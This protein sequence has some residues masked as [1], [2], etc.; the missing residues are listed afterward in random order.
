MSVVE[1]FSADELDWIGCAHRHDEV[2]FRT[3]TGPGR[4]DLE[5]LEQLFFVLSPFPHDTVQ[6]VRT[7]DLPTDM[8]GA[9]AEDAY[10]ALSGGSTL[11]IREAHLRLPQIAVLASE[12]A[13]LLDLEVRANLYLTPPES[14][15]FAPHFD[16]HDVLAMQLLGQKHWSLFPRIDR[17]PISQALLSKPQQILLHTVFGHDPKQFS[18]EDEQSIEVAVGDLLFVPRGVPH[19]ARAGGGAT[20]HC[21]F[22]L[23]HPSRA[24]VIS[25]ASFAAS[26]GSAA[27]TDRWDRA[28]PVHHS[29]QVELGHLEQ[30]DYAFQLLR[31]AS[32]VPLPSR[33][34]RTICM[35]GSVT[36][37]TKVERRPGI[38]PWMGLV[39]GTKQFVF[40]A[41]RYWVPTELE[42]TFEFL[43]RE[44]AF[45]VA[46]LP[47]GGNGSDQV[48][49]CCDLVRR[50]LLQL[51][52]S[53]AG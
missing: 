15:G 37:S 48:D 45:V 47:F 7:P 14:Q 39:D 43:A 21:T 19:Q 40:G 10:A 50:G 23:L 18:T 44:T 20:L 52:G 3:G 2:A 6:R 17:S 16:H 1:P 13:H 42:A 4:L 41:E 22:A 31:Q 53:D 51:G 38:R 46:D 49:L 29:S 30:V 12:L 27:M 36:R 5:D 35:L 9:G 26:G 34:L 8:G 33:F 24:E 25:L 28:V 11:V 32:R